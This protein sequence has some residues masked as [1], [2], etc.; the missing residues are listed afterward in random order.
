LLQL[1]QILSLNVLCWWPSPPLSHCYQFPPTAV[2]LCNSLQKILVCTC[3]LSE[4][5]IAS[6]FMH[7]ILHYPPSFQLQ[8][9]DAGDCFPPGKQFLLLKLWPAYRFVMGIAVFQQALSYLPQTSSTCLYI[10]LKRQ[11]W[12]EC[13]C[14]EM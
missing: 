8:C 7:D 2:P 1:L 6:L 5:S 4:F 3:I 11:S 13:D 10:S 9:T 14:L 12:R